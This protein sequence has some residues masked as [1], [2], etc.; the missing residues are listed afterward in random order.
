[1]NPVRAGMVGDP[2]LYRWSS[3][4]ANAYGEED[5]LVTPH[6]VY[7][8]LGRHDTERRGRYRDLFRETL[9]DHLL[10]QIRQ[11]SNSNAPLGPRTF[12]DEI[13]RKQGRP[14]GLGRRGRPRV[15]HR[16]LPKK[17]L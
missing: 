14:E 10:G 5:P 11:A 1:M 15:A 8:G 16:N 6:A 9:P 17:V 3:H 2:G 7:T 12:I 13:A 4:Q